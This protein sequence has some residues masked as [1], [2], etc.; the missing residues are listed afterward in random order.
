MPTDHDLLL[1]IRNTQENFQSEVQWR[2]KKK[3]QLLKDLDGRTNAL[4]K[5][6]IRI[7][8]DLH[9]C[10]KDLGETE[11]CLA[12]L[13]AK[14]LAPKEYVDKAIKRGKDENTRSQK[15]WITIAALVFTAIGTIIGVAVSLIAH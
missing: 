4:E 8:G 15:I 12:K 7:E 2:L 3:A 1:E 5:N 14:E 9:S 11:E 6:D 10:L 13:K